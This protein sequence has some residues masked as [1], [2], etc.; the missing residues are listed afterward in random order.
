MG[1]SVTTRNARRT[2][3]RELGLCLN[4]A[5]HG[6]AKRYNL[7]DS[8]AAAQ[9]R[10]RARAYERRKGLKLCTTA[11]SHGP[12]ARGLLCEPCN[13]KRRKQNREAKR[14]RKKRTLCASSA[15]HGP[16]TQGTV[17]DLC[18]EKRIRAYV[19]TNA[20]RRRKRI[21]AKRV[22]TCAL[23]GAA[24]GPAVSRN[25]A[26]AVWCAACLARRAAI[27]QRVA[28]RQ[29]AAPS[30]IQTT[31]PT[32]ATLKDV[33]ERGG[34]IDSAGLLGLLLETHSRRNMKK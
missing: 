6:E 4:S 28:K 26:P 27:A 7:C 9:D 19:R 29:Q 33:I 8:C 1:E 23:G 3:N 14:A 15:A 2:Q 10:R 17:C 5:S 16:A 25:G 24:H 18:H 13:E 21:D 30:P 11:P 22:V 31:A 12:A 20:I 32:K 34:S